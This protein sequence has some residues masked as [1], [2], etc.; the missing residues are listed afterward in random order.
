MLRRHVA[1][2]TNVSLCSL[3][4]PLQIKSIYLYAVPI[5]GGSVH[6]SSLSICVTIWKTIKILRK[7]S[8]L[9]LQAG[10]GQGNLPRSSFWCCLLGSVIWSLLGFSQKKL[11]LIDDQELSFWPGTVVLCIRHSSLSLYARWRAEDLPSSKITSRWPMTSAG[12]LI[13]G[14]PS[15]RGNYCMRLNTL[16]TFTTLLM[17]TT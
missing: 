11:E 2:F 1:N 3:V 8:F 7:K 5:R 9:F 17:W 4:L 12:F 13:P 14:Q 15:C 10:V 16:Q 6:R